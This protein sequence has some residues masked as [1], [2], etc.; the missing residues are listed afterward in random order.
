MC[1]WHVVIIQLLCC[2]PGGR[3]CYV[4]WLHS[5]NQRRELNQ[6]DVGSGAFL[7]PCALRRNLN[8]LNL[9]LVCC[10][11]FIG[12]PQCCA[13]EPSARFQSGSHEVPMDIR[14]RQVAFYWILDCSSAAPLAFTLYTLRLQLRCSPL[15]NKDHQRCCCSE[16]QHYPC[17]TNRGSGFLIS[18][19]TTTCQIAA[20]GGGVLPVVVIALTVAI[21]RVVVAGERGF[22]W[23]IHCGL[24]GVV[25][26]LRI[27]HRIRGLLHSVVLC[28]VGRV[29]TTAFGCGINLCGERHDACPYKDAY[30]HDMLRTRGERA[31]KKMFD[32]ICSHDKKLIHTTIVQLCCKASC[33]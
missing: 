18:R 10:F 21:H 14:G 19:V 8:Y 30:P 25:A 11:D 9:L 3:C 29:I 32:C 27:L 22:K 33:F 13:V 31:I 17:F 20:V 15:T 28:G 26:D 24:V 6:W 7:A 12:I 4:G 16:Q 1:L 2:V 23:L 5:A